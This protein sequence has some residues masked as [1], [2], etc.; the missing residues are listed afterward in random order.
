MGNEMKKAEKP[1]AE[2]KAVEAAEVKVARATE[3]AKKEERKPAPTWLKNAAYFKDHVKEGN[4]P[5][6]KGAE[7]D[8]DVIIRTDQVRSAINGYPLTGLN[9]MLAQMKLSEMGSSDRMIAAQYAGKDGKPV[10]EVKPGAKKISLSRW[11]APS[12]TM[13]EFDYYAKSDIVNQ[14]K[15]PQLPGV[16]KDYRNP[17]L[18][19][20][21]NEAEPAKYIGAYNYAQSIG[22]QFKTTA[23][24]RD[25]VKNALSTRLEK[26]FSE[27]NFTSAFEVMRSADDIAKTTAIKQHEQ[28]R[29]KKIE[30]RQSMSHDDGVS[31]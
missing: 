16:R 26:D 31:M 30:R 24:N 29:E 17:N 19:V 13:K 22:A 18:M 27:H 20:E 14:D 6:L 21:C 23:A 3:P 9:Q 2:V 8:G 25:A 7:K 5:F 11:D 28:N 4:V 10:Y 12:Q 1:A 15:L